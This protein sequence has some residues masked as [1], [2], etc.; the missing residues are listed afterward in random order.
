MADEAQSTPKRYV[1]E[2]VGSTD[3]TVLPWV[4]DVQI[5]GYQP[6]EGMFGPYDSRELPV[7]RLLL[8]SFRTPHPPADHT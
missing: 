1:S 2:Q 4:Q 3:P 7:F 6:P 8:M 5:E